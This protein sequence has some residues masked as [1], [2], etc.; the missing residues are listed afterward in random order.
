[1]W[2]KLAIV[3]AL[4]FARALVNS[5]R[6]ALIELAM[7]WTITWL[8]LRYL[9]SLSISA[10]TRS[11]IRYAPVLGAFVLFVLFTGFE[12]FRSWTNYYSGRDLNLLEFGATRLF[13]YYVTSFNNGAYL[14][15]HLDPL[16]APYFT[17]HFLWG[18]PLT[19]PVIS[20]LFANPILDSTD[21]WFYFPFLEANANVEYNNADGF[22]FPLM[23]YGVAGGLLY[24]LLIGIVC[25]F[26]YESFRRK[27]LA[28]MLLYP[29]TFLGLIELPLALYWGEGRSFPSLLLLAAAPVVLWFTRQSGYPARSLA[30][31]SRVHQ[32]TI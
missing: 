24:W 30:P 12:Y 29:A 2:F 11:F 32:T 6:F 25:G 15:S 1:V 31:A 21:K 8:G 19:S 23:D 10:R 22:L 18:F 26:L 13:G 16:S 28:G 27:Q 17:L 14:L 3:I 7:P 20:R 4:A 9:G 5:E